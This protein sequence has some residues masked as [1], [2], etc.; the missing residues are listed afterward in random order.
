MESFLFAVAQALYLFAPLLAAAALSAV[1]LRWDLLAWLK[2]PI[3][4]GATLG[5][6]RVFGDN[7]TWRGVF[8]AVAGSV[9]A[10]AAQK[11]LIG[12]AAGRLAVVDYE[13][14]GGVWLGL[15]LG[16]GATLGELPNSFVKRR[17]D[18]APGASTRGAWGALF[19][20]WDQLD[21]LTTTWPLLL[22]WIRPSLL[23]VGASVALVLV[24]HPLVALVG[25]VVGARRTAR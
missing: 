3:D 14:A 2:R 18:V 6:R 11:Y 23:L 4:G 8:V 25:Y 24:V 1:V 9:A 5:G 21:L 22:F 16:G 7:K 19:Y 10:V 13:R 12:G 20:F 15:A 17:L